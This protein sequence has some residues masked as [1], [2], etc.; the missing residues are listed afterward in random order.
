M[1]RPIPVTR[2]AVAALLA[3]LSLVA[4]GLTLGVLGTFAQAGEP[5]WPAAHSASPAVPGPPV[6]LGPSAIDFAL[7]EP[8]PVALRAREAN[9]WVAA[10]AARVPGQADDPWAIIDQCMRDDMAGS[11]A[12]PDDDTP[13]ASIAVA[14]NGVITFTRGYGVKDVDTGGT[15]DSNTLFRIGSTTKMMTAAAVMQLVEAGTVDLDAPLSRYLPEYRL[16]HPWS[17]DDLTLHHLLSHQ[18]GHIDQYFTQDL[19]MSLLDWVQATGALSLPLYAAPGSFWNY[20]NPNF[21]LAGAVVER[22]GHL[23]YHDY[24][25]QKIW[26]PAGMPL[27]T[28][29]GR[30]VISTSNYATGYHAGEALDP[31][32]LDIPW[33]GPAGTAFSTP[34]E[35][36]SWALLMQR[37]DDAVLSAAS[38]QRMQTRHA[39]QGYLPWM[40]YGYGI[41]IT[42]WRDKADPAERVVV[43]DH[44]GNIYGGSSQ[45][46]WIPDRSVVVSVL[47][48]TIRSLDNAA[49][50]AVETL[51]GI[52]MIPSDSE[53]KPPEAWD[54]YVGTYSMMDLFLWPW[55]AAVSRDGDL[56]TLD[57]NDL[58]G[59]ALIMGERM[60]MIY[61][62]SDVVFARAQSMLS[63][64]GA[65]F[66]FIRDRADPGRVRYMRNRNTVGQRVGQF[67]Q[68]VSLEGAACAPV[69]F[70]SELDMPVLSVHARGLMTPTRLISVPLALD[71]PNDPSAASI[72]HDFTVGQGGAD[73]VYVLADTEPDDTVGLYLLADTNGD[74]QFASADGELVTAGL[75]VPGTS[76]LHATDPLPAG[77][78]Q[79][80]VHGAVV[81]GAD[82]TVSVEVTVFEGQN[83][84]LENWPRGLSDGATWEMRV[85]ADDVKELT[86]P[87]SGTIEFAY[88]SPPRRFRIMVDWRPVARSPH[89]R[90]FLPLSWKDGALP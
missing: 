38:K 36:V 9:A 76:L 32:A 73:A 6:R 34:T 33:L 65:D 85:C 21:S 30:A 58:P 12:T 60:S 11:P 29:D 13:A 22:E 78:Y 47:A 79:L 72:K 41:M 1:P 43:F 14:V 7:P 67:P 69:R 39:S 18:T 68:R 75:G 55:T 35:M 40:D 87:M 37:G 53:E 56:L 74:G 25:A 57:F 89:K 5:T 51:A 2:S 71:D 24:V 64:G 77:R 4:A 62:F 86:A 82:S 49:A 88:D 66:S 16:G 27:T 59:G 46:F 28:L 80:W 54:A 17:G 70:K 19:T 48:N 83:L 61:I 63:P 42:D 50:C 10:S 26:D 20:A 90:L 8:V 15:V 84:R 52:E 23:P 44:G 31:T 81:G 3:G 45:L